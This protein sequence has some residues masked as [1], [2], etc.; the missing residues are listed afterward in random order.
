LNDYDPVMV[1]SD[2][3]GTAVRKLKQVLLAQH[4]DKKAA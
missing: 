1:L 2:M 3:S 4:E